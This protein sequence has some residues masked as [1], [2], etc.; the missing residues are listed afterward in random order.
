MANE[1]KL[2][3]K[4][5]IP[6][7]LEVAGDMPDRWVEGMLNNAER[8]HDRLLEVLSSEGKFQDRLAEVSSPKWKKMVDPTFVSEAGKSK[9][10]M[11]SFQ[12]KKLAESFA[13]FVE[14]YGRAFATVD[15]VFAKWFKEQVTNAKDRWAIAV[16]NGTL[17][18]TGDKIRG[19]VVPQIG[20]WMTGD[21]KANKF[22]EHV[23]VISGGPYDF[24]K[25]GLRKQFRSAVTNLLVS[26]GMYILKADMDAGEIAAQ[27]ARLVD[28]ANSFADA[29]VKPFVVGGGATDSLLE[30]E[31]SDPEFKL[32]ARIVLV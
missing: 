19:M 22:T 13:K 4:I 3:L 12:Y 27:N 23:E 32:H 26:T 31:Y 20:Y 25:A 28:L 6:V 21:P 8:M 24:T 7:S 11:V 9:A 2:D 14:K 29:T 30:Y 5:T 16:S 10:N 18:F 15:G 1:V 17:R